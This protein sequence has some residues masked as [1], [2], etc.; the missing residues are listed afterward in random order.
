V[1]GRVS[2]E[3]SQSELEMVRVQYEVYIEEHPGVANRNLNLV[4]LA[5]INPL[6]N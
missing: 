2:I 6:P 4:G 1:N 5:G 3:C